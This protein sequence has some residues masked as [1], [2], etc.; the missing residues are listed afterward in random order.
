MDHQLTQRHNL[1]F[2]HEAD[3][4]DTED[5]PPAMTLNTLVQHLKPS[6]RVSDTLKTFGNVWNLR[7]STINGER[8]AL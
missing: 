8:S 2:V 1:N 7:T 4:S 3:D 5:P 6:V